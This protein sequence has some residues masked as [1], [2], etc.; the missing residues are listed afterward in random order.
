M[1]EKPTLDP[2]TQALE[3]RLA[4]IPP[5]V[6][7]RRREQLLYEC[8][9]AAGRRGALPIIRRWQAAAVLLGVGMASLGLIR[10]ATQFSPTSTVHVPLPSSEP[11]KTEPRDE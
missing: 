11:P 10:P 7:E 9:R 4:A 5:P 6:S 3:A 2:I 8:G 1:N